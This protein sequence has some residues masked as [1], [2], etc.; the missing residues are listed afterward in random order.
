VD[1][2]NPIIIMTSN[3]GANHQLAQE[4]V[5][6]RTDRHRPTLDEEMLKQSVHQSLKQTFRPEFLN[7]VDEI[8]VFTSLR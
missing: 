7:R 2:R 4:P 1:F 3:L 5:E 8:I 6:F